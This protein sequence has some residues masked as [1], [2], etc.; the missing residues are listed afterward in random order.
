MI[1][2]SNTSIVFQSS[3]KAI[4]AVARLQ[5]DPVHIVQSSKKII[6]AVQRFQNDP[7]TT[8]LTNMSEAAAASD[9]KS[10][11]G[12]QPVLASQ[13]AKDEQAQSI[14]KQTASR[15]GYFPLGYKDAIHQWVCISIVPFITV[16][17][18]C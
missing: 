7:N 14:S 10:G 12:Q 13:R 2:N 6:A 16:L 18:G 1:K 11:R 4:A 5:K 17:R 15:M 9:Q 8:L 3:R